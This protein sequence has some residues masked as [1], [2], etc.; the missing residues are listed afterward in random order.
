MIHARGQP[1]RRVLATLVVTHEVRVA[2]E[3][4]ER[5]RE[6]L[7]LQHR[8][9]SDRSAGADQRVAG[10][11]QGAG[12]G[13]DWT[14]AVP[15]FAGKALVHAL[16]ARFLRFAQVEIGEQPPQGYTNAADQ[17]LLDAAQPPHELRQQ[18]A[19][20]AVGE[21]KVDVLLLNNAGD[22]GFCSHLSVIR[23]Q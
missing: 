9:S 10:T 6:P 8:P 20:N 1:Q 11:H 19:W 14:H 18:P 4:E 21:Q 12:V 22:Q 5:V 2:Q 13:I 17:R 7:R 23:L 15:Q 16:E 3:I